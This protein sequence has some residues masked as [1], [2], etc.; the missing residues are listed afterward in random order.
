MRRRYVAL[1]VLLGVVVL[2]GSALF[3]VSAAVYEQAARV[4]PDCGGHYQGYSPAAWS[5]PRWATDFDPEPYL[6]SDYE[7]VRMPSRD[8]GIEL[9]TWWLP[10]DDPAAPAIVVIHGRSACIRHPEV[11]APAAMLHRLGYAV[12]LVDLR[13]HGASTIEDGYYAGGTEEY[14]DVMGAIDWLLARETPPRGIGVLGTSLGAATAV[15]AGGADD[16]VQAVWEDS[17]YSEMVRRVAEDLEQRGLPTFLAP[18]TVLLAR[19]FAGDDLASHTVLG[20]TRNLTG[21]H[22]FITHG[23]DDDATYVSHAHALLEAAEEADVIVE[24]WIVPDAGHVDALFQHPEE[25]ESR[26]GAFFGA[27]FE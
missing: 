26:L 10:A 12:L 22:L 24:S 14:R 2:L 15:I 21:R 16:R 5:G 23:E 9:H 4:E 20:E 6:T 7:T 17:S 18:A 1:A 25:Y 13:D 8:D 19:L 3:G 27:A 11:L